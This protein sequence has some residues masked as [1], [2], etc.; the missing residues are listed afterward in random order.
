MVLVV[1]FDGLCEPVNPGG[2]A[3]YGF[4]VYRDGLRV[5]EGKGVVGAGYLGDDVTN[6]VAEYTALVKAL[7]LLLQRDFIGEELV[8]RGDSQLAIRQLQGVYAVR[9]PRIA[10]LYRKVR[11]LLSRFP[12]VRF[13]W[14]PR[15][16]NAEA[17]ALSRAAYE[18]FLR[19]HPE[20]LASYS[21]HRCGRPLSFEGPAPK[22]RRSI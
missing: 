15:E 21:L 11:E 8:I 13:E 5:A 22:R 2:I 10:P 18:E 17:D 14:V 12:R 1:Y 6:N 20:A 16:E 19:K 3:T 7:E 4:V 9:S